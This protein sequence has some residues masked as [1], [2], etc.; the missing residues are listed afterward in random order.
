MQRLYRTTADNGLTNRA[1]LDWCVKPRFTPRSLSHSSGDT[2]RAE[3]MT[4]NN[5]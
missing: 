5:H 1:A 4:V 3:A 2:A